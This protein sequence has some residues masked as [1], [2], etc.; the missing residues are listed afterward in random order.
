MQT[1]EIQDKYNPF[2]I[3]VIK[4]TKCRHYY[5]NQKIHGRMHYK[6]FSKVKKSNLLNAVLFD[7]KEGG[8]V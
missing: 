6:K 2:K 7:F 4:K 8:N 5:V 3:W 1:I